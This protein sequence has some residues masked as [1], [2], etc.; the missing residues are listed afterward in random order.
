MSALV[1]QVVNALAL[2]GVA[3]IVALIIRLWLSKREQAQNLS[4]SIVAAQLRA[5]IGEQSKTQQRAIREA[6]QGESPAEQLAKLG[7]TRREDR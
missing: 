7:N 1:G 4:E 5:H 6:L 2:V 3:A